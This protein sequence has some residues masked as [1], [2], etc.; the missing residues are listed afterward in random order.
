V[1]TFIKAGNKVFSIGTLLLYGTTLSAFQPPRD[2]QQAPSNAI[3]PRSAYPQRQITDAK[4]VDA[5]KN[6]FSVRCAFCHGSD[7]RGGEGGPNLLHS[8]TVLKDENGELIQPL[9]RNG[10]PA[11]GMPAFDLDDV[12]MKSVVAF[13]HSIPVSS[14]ERTSAVLQIPLG[15]AK[16]GEVA[17]TQHCASC[18][19]ITGDL[20][21]IGVKV[22]DPK[23]LQQTWLMPGTRGSAPEV[24]VK[25]KRVQVT[26][27]NGQS[28]SGR[29]VR[30]DDFNVTLQLEDGSTRTVESVGENDPQVVVSDPLEG[31]IKLL[32]QYTD[33]SIHD[34]TAY[35]ES[36]K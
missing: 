32:P 22:P 14:H 25:P 36:A 10:R 4:L 6:V 20:R 30:R 28:I 15:D 2:I 29:L 27:R 5:G 21:G 35:L 17:F 8:E 31:H 33:K 26:L 3:Q 13:L 16:A 12:Q 24:V 11:Q 9:V 18:H 23:V 1:R 34:I 7:A 19:S